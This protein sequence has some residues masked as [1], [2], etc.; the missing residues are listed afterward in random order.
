MSAT[1]LCLVGCTV[2][3][4]IVAFCYTAKRESFVTRG[5]GKRWEVCERKNSTN[6]TLWA[7]PTWTPPAASTARDFSV[8]RPPAVLPL[9]RMAESDAIRL[10]FSS[11]QGQKKSFCG[12]AESLRDAKTP[13]QQ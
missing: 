7:P 4:G 5:D 9:H 11:K 10:R 13:C 2:N 8:Q 1:R 12:V 6:S 3:L